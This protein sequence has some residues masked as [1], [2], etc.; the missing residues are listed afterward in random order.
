M[1]TRIFAFLFFIMAG[2][3]ASA[4]TTKEKAAALRAELRGEIARAWDTNMYNWN[5]EKAKKALRMDDCAEA[6]LLRGECYRDLKK[7]DDAIADFK[8]AIKLDPQYIDAYLTLGNFYN[9]QDKS[10]EALENF[11]KVLELSPGNADA[12]RGIAVSYYTLKRW[13]ESQAL[14]TKLMDA[15]KDKAPWYYILGRL[16]LDRGKYRESVDWFRKALA[17]TPKDEYT[18][19]YLNKALQLLPV[20][21]NIATAD[22]KNRTVAQGCKSGNCNTGDGLAYLKSADGKNSWQYKGHFVNGLRNGQGSSKDSTGGDKPYLICYE[23]NFSNDKKEG[24]SRAF[25][26]TWNAGK[27][28]WVTVVEWDGFFSNDA[29]NG[30]AKVS[31][32]DASGNGDTIAVLSGR[33][34]D[35]VQKEGK[36]TYIHYS[37]YMNGTWTSNDWSRPTATVTFTPKGTHDVIEGMFKND[38]KDSPFDCDGKYY[39]VRNKKAKT[40]PFKADGPAWL[41]TIYWPIA[42][43]DAIRIVDGPGVSLEEFDRQEQARQN[44][45]QT[46]NN[47]APV[48][49]KVQRIRTTCSV[50]FGSGQT[51]RLEDWS[52][53]SSTT[54]ARVYQ[55]CYRCHGTGYE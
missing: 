1:T 27:K 42:A 54:I 46:G 19:E 18:R 3:L 23:G 36:R 51:S 12:T 30:D 10:T 31:F 34:L 53:S 45:S 21:Q 9:S 22:N 39:S 7:Y 50:C 55:T 40:Y 25:K 15:D 24:K 20:D 11:N 17:L 33:Y 13:D 4:Q 16:N 41:Y 29:L 48:T 37:D 26:K 8:K 38:D 49:R 44:N 47:T 28:A 5:M 14:F 2:L 32:F 43:A 52:N 35:N 6:Y